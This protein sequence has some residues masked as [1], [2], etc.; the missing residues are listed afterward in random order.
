MVYTLVAHFHVKEG[1]DVEDKILNKLVEASQTYMKDAE[2]IGILYV[3][4]DTRKWT[5][6]ERYVRERT[7]N[8]NNN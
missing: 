2:V 8:T 6:I 3:H 5:I 7:S 4:A 1:K